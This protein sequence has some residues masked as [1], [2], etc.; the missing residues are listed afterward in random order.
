MLLG[1]KL[2]TTLI[3][4]LKMMQKLRHLKTEKFMIW[5]LPLQ[6]VIFQVNLL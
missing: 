3:H 1:L 4:L 6:T 2:E 5:N